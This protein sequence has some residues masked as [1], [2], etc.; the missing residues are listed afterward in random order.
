MVKTVT[1]TQKARELGDRLK[2]ERM[3]Q[4]IAQKELAKQAGCAAQTLLDIEYGN[5]EY[6]RFLPKIADVLGVSVHWLQTGEG[7]ANRPESAA[8]PVGLVPWSYYTELASADVDAQITD[9]VDGCPVNHSKN[10]Y[11]L[12]ADD[13]A[14]FA[15]T[16][17]VNQGDWLFVDNDRAEDGLVVCMMAGWNRAE[18]RELTSLGGRQM[19]RT[20]NPALPQQLL[21]VQSFTRRA[22]YVGALQVPGQDALPCLVL[23]RVIFKG[24]PW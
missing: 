4:G 18:L 16:G 13:T 14:A 7:K 8:V 17:V 22:D 5:V 12:L 2:R 21:P 6:S 19:L 3:R 24:A 15:M 23:G 11:C 1:G 10:T 20:T 9:W